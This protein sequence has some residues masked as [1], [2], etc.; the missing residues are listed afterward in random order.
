MSYQTETPYPS[1]KLNILEYLY[2]V[3][4]Y[5][6]EYPYAKRSSS[7]LMI[8]TMRGGAVVTG[9]SG[10]VS[11]SVAGIPSVDSEV[12]G[13]SGFSVNILLLWVLSSGS[14]V[15]SDGSDPVSAGASSVS[16]GRSAAAARSSAP[17]PSVVCPASETDPSVISSGIGLSEESSPSSAEEFP[18]SVSSEPSAVVSSG[19]REGSFS[20]GAIVSAEAVI[21]A[22]SVFPVS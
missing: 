10:S 12:S 18:V 14:P 4:R 15:V 13:F 1:E 21:S 9:G 19:G 16:S 6:E 17:P 20:S 3:S 7:V 5:Q 2:P 8:S 11:V 22:L